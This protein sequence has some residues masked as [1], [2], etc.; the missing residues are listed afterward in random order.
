VSGKTK[1]IFGIPLALLL[2]GGLALLGFFLF[3]TPAKSEG[4][5]IDTSHLSDGIY[6]GQF[7]SGPN[8]AEVEVTI[9][10]HRI[11]EIRVVR[12]VASW[13]GKNA[14]PAVPERIIAAQST[15]VDVVTG[16]THSSRVIMNAVED[17]VRKS[18]A[19]AGK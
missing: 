11:A 8:R 9:R 16:A 18:Y 14:E 6:Q 3:S 10:D 4:G 5:V 1:I 17:A 2:V 7:R 12:N 13:I 15:D 19:R